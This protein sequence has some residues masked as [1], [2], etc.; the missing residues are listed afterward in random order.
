M[1]Y[2]LVIQMTINDLL[3][4]DSNQTMIHP[5][6]PPRAPTPHKADFVS[7]IIDNPAFEEDDNELNDK[8]KVSFSLK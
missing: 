2:Y 6:D 3:I 7:F 4:D 8:D 1:N 5:P